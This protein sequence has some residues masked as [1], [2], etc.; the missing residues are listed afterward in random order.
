MEESV[1]MITGY[2]TGVFDLFHIGHLNLL[3]NAKKRCDELIVG[4]SLNELVFSYKRRY[5]IIPDFQRIEIIR[6]LKCVDRAYLIDFRDKFRGWKE[7]RF[8]II[9]VGDD[10]KGNILWE[11]WEE[12]LAK[13]GAKVMYLPYTLEQSTTKI[14]ES[15]I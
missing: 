13:V 3:R 11:K 14:I 7:F 2:A 1:K 15:I 5:P 12:K 9:F 10:W 6:A 8:D 4:V